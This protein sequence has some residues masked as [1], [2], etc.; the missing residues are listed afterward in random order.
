MVFDKW[1]FFYFH[2]ESIFINRNTILRK[3]YPFLPFI[4]LYGFAL[5]SNSNSPSIWIITSLWQCHPFFTG[6]PRVGHEHNSVL[7][8]HMLLHSPSSFGLR[9]CLHWWAWPIALGFQ[10]NSPNLTF[11]SC[12]SLTLLVLVF[13]I[14]FSTVHCPYLSLTFTRKFLLLS[15]K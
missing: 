8:C 14:I 10:S 5:I 3:S 1:W 13:S 4:Y 11:N 15:E 12:L 6:G 9:L 7:V 2:Y